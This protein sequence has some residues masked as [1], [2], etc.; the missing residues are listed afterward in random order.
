MGKLVSPKVFLLG[1]TQVDIKGLEAY[2]KYT[3]QEAFMDVFW[4][5]VNEQGISHGEAL[6][7]IYA[8]LCY[9]AIIKGKNANISRVRDIPDNIMACFDSAHGSVFEH[10]SINFVVTDCSRVYT[11][12]QVRHR[13]GWAYSQTSGRYCRLDSIDLVWDP[14]LDPVKALFMHGLRY[15]ED[16]VYLAECALGLRKPN[17]FNPNS[18]AQKYLHL[19]ESPWDSA[20]GIDYEAHKWVPDD[21]FNFETRK[22]LTSAIR[23]IA[24]N[25]Q[26]NEIGMSCNIRALRQVVQLRTAAGAEYEIRDVYNQ[27]Y[28]ITR[29]R[30]KL[31][32]HGARTKEVGGMR[33]VYG[34]KQQPFDILPG[35]PKALEFYTSDDLHEELRRRQAA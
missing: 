8:K 15:I 30:F 25:G 31:V 34:M 7:S 24:P 29:E 35:D 22:K 20:S 14:I 17:P 32:F 6:C 2:L 16:T 9:A 27:I 21:S 23:R 19:R 10:A 1:Y 18:T 13:A 28:D 5:A 4:A 33:V 26:A 12:E 3:D 11:H